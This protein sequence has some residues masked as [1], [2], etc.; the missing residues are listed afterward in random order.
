MLKKKKKEGKTEV[1]IGNVCVCYMATCVDGL[2]KN[3]EETGNTLFLWK[4][5]EG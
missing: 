5:T 4:G 3:A 1:V 2:R